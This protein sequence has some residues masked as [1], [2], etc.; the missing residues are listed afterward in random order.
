MRH[1]WRKEEA[2]AKLD[3]PAP[4]VSGKRGG[5]ERGEFWSCYRY[6]G[7]GREGEREG[8]WREES[9]K[10]RK[11]QVNEQKRETCFGLVTGTRG[12]GGREGG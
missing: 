7:A 6:E 8:G 9:E 12:Q 4:P 11:V 5:R 2:V 3:A 1:I 10:R